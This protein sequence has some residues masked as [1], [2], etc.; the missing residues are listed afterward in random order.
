MMTV[1]KCVKLTCG[2]ATD[3]LHFILFRYTRVTHGALDSPGPR[4]AREALIGAWNCVCLS[5]GAP[6][7]PC[8]RLRDGD[9]LG[10]RGTDSIYARDVHQ[11]TG[12]T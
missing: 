11:L 5:T 4:A 2:Y 6:E 3:A 7:G 10:H 9:T 12:L 8:V 1:S